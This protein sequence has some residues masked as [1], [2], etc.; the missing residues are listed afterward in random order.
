MDL[1]G[2][3]CFMTLGLMLLA[4]GA[5]AVVRVFQVRAEQRRGGP[6][7]IARRS[8]EADAPR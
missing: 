1:G 8:E 5:W 6:D 7:P 3:I 2:A 4:G